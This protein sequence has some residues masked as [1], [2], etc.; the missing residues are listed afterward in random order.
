M[1]PDGHQITG[2]VMEKGNRTDIPI[3]IVTAKAFSPVPS[4]TPSPPTPPGNDDHTWW[5]VGAVICVLLILAGLAVAYYLFNKRR[6]RAPG[7]R[8]NPEA[9]VTLAES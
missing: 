4:P 7:G 1:A 6:Q 9:A 2:L 5:I 3:G 8:W